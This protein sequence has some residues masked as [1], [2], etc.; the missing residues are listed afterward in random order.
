[1]LYQHDTKMRFGRES[2]VS[3]VIQFNILVYNKINMILYR[4]FGNSSVRARRVSR[5][6]S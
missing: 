6:A 3:A 1:M 5:D 4:F 2:A